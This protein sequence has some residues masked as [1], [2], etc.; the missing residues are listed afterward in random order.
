M[1]TALSVNN[2]C[3]KLIGSVSHSVVS[4]SLQPHGLQPTRLLCPWDFPGK[5]TGVGCHFLLQGIF[6][7]RDR[8]QVS[9]TAGG[10]SHQGSPVQHRHTTNTQP[11]GQV[12][13]TWMGRSRWRFCDAGSL[14]SWDAPLEEN[15]YKLSVQSKRRNIHEKKEPQWVT[16]CK[17]L[18]N[19]INTTRKPQ[20]YF[21]YFLSLVTKVLD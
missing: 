12:T 8:T 9:C 4:D 13:K 17:K 2:V 3:V 18:I 20:K 1:L 5:N 21:N 14:H 16:A 10:F 19:T 7:P 11:P 6:W 15:E